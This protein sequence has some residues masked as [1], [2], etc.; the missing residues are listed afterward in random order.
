MPPN[1]DY[2]ANLPKLNNPGLVGDD[3]DNVPNSEM[4]VLNY[5]HRGDDQLGVSKIRDDGPVIGLAGL[6][7]LDALAPNLDIV[8]LPFAVNVDLLGQVQ[9][10]FAF[11]AEN[12]LKVVD[13]LLGKLNLVFHVPYRHQGFPPVDLP[14]FL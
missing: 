13:A 7:Q 1:S 6:V 11:P 9:S 10:P 12:V 14:W 2:K 8:K 4:G 3:H 5:H